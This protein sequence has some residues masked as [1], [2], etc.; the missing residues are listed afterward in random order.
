MA[1]RYDMTAARAAYD[2]TPAAETAALFWHAVANKLA[3]GVHGVSL[4]LGRGGEGW[5]PKLTRRKPCR[6]CGE[7]YTWHAFAD[8]GRVRVCVECGR[9]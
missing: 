1:E 2:A 5:A 6:E 7:R 9:A 4:R 8:G 3:R